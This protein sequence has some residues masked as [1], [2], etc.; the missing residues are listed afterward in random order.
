MSSVS[1]NAAQ[2]ATE[3]GLVL[4]RVS[5]S[6]VKMTEYENRLEAWSHYLSLKSNI[7]D[8][9][10]G[11][12]SS[13]KITNAGLRERPIMERITCAEKHSAEFTSIDT[14]KAFKFVVRFDYIYCNLQ[15]IVRSTLERAKDTA[16]DY[17]NQFKH[18]YTETITPDG[19]MHTYKISQKSYTVIVTI[20]REDNDEQAIRELRKK[21]QQEQIR[22]EQ[23]EKARQEQIMQKEFTADMK[24]E[25][26]RVEQMRLKEEEECVE[27]AIEISKQ[28]VIEDY[29]M[30]EARLREEADAKKLREKEIEYLLNLE[31][32][33]EDLDDLDEYLY[34]SDEDLD[35]LEEDLDE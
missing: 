28:T 30:R 5:G 18:S 12:P 23:R 33:D 31:D 1:S 10:A 7:Y 29:E 19:L 27:N 6:G 8:I 9:C 22:Q 15:P 21:A 14:P 35:D 34:E 3:K 11:Y 16:L 17:L 25:Q 4:Y 26:A 24:R 20:T 32:S 13:V 2:D